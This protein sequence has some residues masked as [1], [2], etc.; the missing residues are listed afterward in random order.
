MVSNTL[1]NSGRV[2]NLP[3]LGHS[4][5][6]Y[7]RRKMTA[8]LQ[9]EGKHVIAGTV[10]WLKCDEAL[11]GVICGRNLRTMIPAK[12]GIHADDLLDRNITSP[13][14]DRGIAHHEFETTGCD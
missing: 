10:D 3:R 4:R 14:F 12:D 6:V 8:H 11:N 1:T 2:V 9:L 5:A 13:R 7:G